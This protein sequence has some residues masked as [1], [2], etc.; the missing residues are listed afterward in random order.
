MNKR[1]RKKLNK[2]LKNHAD[3]VQSRA[4]Q[5][6]NEKEYYSTKQPRSTKTFLHNISKEAAARMHKPYR[7]KPQKEPELLNAYVKPTMGSIDKTKRKTYRIF[8]DT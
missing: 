6:A 3:N 7:P 1:A 2:R 8:S 4:K 5:K